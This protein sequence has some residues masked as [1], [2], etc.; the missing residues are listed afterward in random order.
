MDQQIERESEPET[1]A[2]KPPI[3]KHHIQ[4][5]NWVDMAAY[6]DSSARTGLQPLHRQVM[7]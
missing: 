7:N 1:Q 6:T 5:M 4:S 3:Q 2:G